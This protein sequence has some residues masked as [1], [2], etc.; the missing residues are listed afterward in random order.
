MALT[1]NR[2]LRFPDQQALARAAA[3]LVVESLGLAAAPSFNLTGGN[4]IMGLYRLLG[5]EYAGAIDWPSLVITW[6]DERFVPR[7]DPDHNASAARQVLLNNV[8]IDPG[9]VHEIPTEG[10]SLE[11]CAAAYAET[12]EGIAARGEFLFDVTLLSLGDDGHIASLIPGQPVLEEREALAAAVPHGR[13]EPRI[14]LTYPALARSARLILI[15]SG[16][17]K[18]A[19]LKDL[20]AGAE[21]YPASR[22]RVDGELV[23][24]AD[25]AAIGK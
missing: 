3:D 17:K 21:Q 22:L 8:P 1:A 23:L 11:D 15:A 24:L 12:L 10:A 25:E 7:G 16:E 20:L 13:P 4:S 6:G 18:A 19:V 14:T 5:G 2:V 9:R